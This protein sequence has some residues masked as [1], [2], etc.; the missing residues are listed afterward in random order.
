MWQTSEAVVRNICKWLL[1]GIIAMFAGCSSAKASGNL[2]PTA[3]PLPGGLGGIGFDDLGYD[4]Q[5]SKVL[6]PAGNTGNLDLIDP[7][8]LA[9]TT[10]TGFSAQG[11]FTGGHGE[12]ITSADKMT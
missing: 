1:L 9:V 4:A 5:F 6:V 3:V 12:G 2:H 10:I 11:P 7:K 8:T